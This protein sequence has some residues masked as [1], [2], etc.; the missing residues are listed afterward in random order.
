MESILV[1]LLGGG[2]VLLFVH[3]GPRARTMSLGEGQ[4]NAP[5]KAAVPGST[6]KGRK[7]K[8][9]EPLRESKNGQQTIPQMFSGKKVQNCNLED[10]QK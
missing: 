3:D 7:K 1:T 4:K 2:K 6:R 10:R 5:R 8:M 9:K